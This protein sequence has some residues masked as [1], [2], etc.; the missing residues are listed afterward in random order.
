M[1]PRSACLVVRTPL[2]RGPSRRGRSGVKTRS[3]FQLPHRGD[4][5]GRASNFL[6]SRGCEGC[7]HHFRS[8]PHGSRVTGRPHL[9]LSNPV[10]AQVS[11]PGGRE[12]PPGSQRCCCWLW[13]RERDFH[14]L[15]LVRGRQAWRPHSWAVT[16]PRS[17][18]MCQKGGALSKEVPAGRRQAPPPPTPEGTP[19]AWLPGKSG[20]LSRETGDIWCLMLPGMEEP[21]LRRRRSFLP[22]Q[23]DEGVEPSSSSYWREMK[24]ELGRRPRLRPE[25]SLS[26]SVLREEVSSEIP[27]CGPLATQ[28]VHAEGGVWKEA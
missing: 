20:D 1:G 27:S 8:R 19:Q 15:G 5:G 13:R 10:P 21:V 25:V 9:W 12:A 22:P 28:H 23:G 7:T 17:C 14:R 11:F 16:G 4:G 24:S 3:T 6:Q 18:T 26:L 2:E